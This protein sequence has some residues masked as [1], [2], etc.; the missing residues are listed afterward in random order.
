MLP[1]EQARPFGPGELPQA[2]SFPRS[3]ASL[4]R[5]QTDYIDLYQLHGYDPVTPIEETLGALDDLV[6][7]G[8]SATVGCSNFLTYQLV[9]AI[10]EVR[11]MDWPVLTPYSSLQPDLSPDRARDASIL[12]RRRS[13]RDPYNPCGWLLSGKAQSGGSADWRLEIH[14][15]HSGRNYQERTGTIGSSTTVEQLLPLAEAAG[16]SS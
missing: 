15:G 14:L 8:K 2:H 9:R 3:N 13:G 5:L 11:H 12:R 6:Q 1:V 4:R 10:A 16:V 7:Q